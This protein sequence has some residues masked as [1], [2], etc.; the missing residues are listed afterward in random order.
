MLSAC[1]VAFTVE[2]DN[3]AEHRMP[4]RTARHGASDP[5]APRA[6]WLVSQA[7]WANVLQYV[8]P[9]GVTV[10]ELAARARVSF[11][12]LPGLTRWGYVTVSDDAE[13]VVRATEAGPRAQEVWRPLAGEIEQHW[14]QRFGSGAIGDLRS[15]L[16]TIATQLEVDLPAYLPVTSPTQNGKVELPAPRDPGRPTETGGDVSVLLARVLLGFTLDFERESR[17]SLPVCADTLRV[18]DADGVRVRDLPA[19]SGV[20]KEAQAMAV[21]FLARR[22]CVVVEA[23]PTASRGQRVRLTDR[24]ARARSNYLRHLAATEWSWRDHFGA[25]AVRRPARG[26]RAAGRGRADRRCVTA[27]CGPDPTPGR[28]AGPGPATGDVAA[29]PDG[30]APGRLSGRELGRHGAGEDAECRPQGGSEITGKM[31]SL[32]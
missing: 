23:D 6:P 1:L 4:H 17:L 5:A 31:S 21:G 12:Q 10:A 9:A 32:R 25:A 30:P 2:F 27:V 26:A 24:G 19:R 28:V 22:E 14:T 29:P 20:S 18:L 11:L 8:E 16:V 3:E 15:A 13:P 7:M